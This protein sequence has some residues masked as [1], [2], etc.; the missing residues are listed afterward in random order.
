MRIVISS[1]LV[2]TACAL[3][4]IGVISVSREI[5]WM[6]LLNERHW[7]RVTVHYGQF[8]IVHAR[9]SNQTQPPVRE[10]FRSPVL[11]QFGFRAGTNRQWRYHGLTCPIWAMVGILSIQ[12]GIALVR[13]PLLG[14]RRR[15]RNE[16]PLCGYSLVGC[17][18]DACP[19]CGTT[20]VAVKT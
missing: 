14:R 11:G 5:G 2:A 17:V 16:C 6:G 13:G 15:R 9:V 1:I 7:G 12:P 19:E 10:G 4:V 8:D 20:R 18:S 3:T